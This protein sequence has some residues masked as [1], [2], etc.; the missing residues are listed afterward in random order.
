MVGRK[1]LYVGCSMEG[2]GGKHYAKSFCRL[3]YV[4]QRKAEHKVEEDVKAQLT[5]S[6]SSSSSSEFVSS[7]SEFVKAVADAP[8]NSTIIFKD[9][10][11]GNEV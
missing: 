7:S 4:K 2:C 9:E 10:S 1:A 6:I 3:H 11:T 5:P 8:D